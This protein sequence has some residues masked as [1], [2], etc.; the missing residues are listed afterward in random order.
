MNA[1][2]SLRVI[3]D[4]LDNRF[5][6]GCLFAR[7][8]GHTLGLRDGATR[9]ER[10]LIRFSGFAYQCVISIQNAEPTMGLIGASILK[11]LGSSIFVHRAQSS[12]V[13]NKH[14]NSAAAAVVSTLPLA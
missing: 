7:R 13:A 4:D 9:V 14:S 2:S 12:R 3:L 11:T 10:T 8:S 6:L 5:D 1:L